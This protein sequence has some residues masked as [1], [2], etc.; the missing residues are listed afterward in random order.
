MR[1]LEPHKGKR[2]ARVAA[3]ILRD[4]PEI[5]RAA[6]ELPGD[7]MVSVTDVE[8]TDD[9]S[10]AR[11]FFSVIGD[12]EERQAAALERLLNSKKGTVRSELARRL[13]MR[14]HPDIRFIYDST[15]A[16]AARIEELFRQI[17]GESN[18]PSGESA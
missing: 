14:Q 5:L 13:V 9:L 11:I 10:F 2:P 16:R 7:A 1:P 4:L 12:H 15:P 18:P 3:E 17:H 6:V 8:V